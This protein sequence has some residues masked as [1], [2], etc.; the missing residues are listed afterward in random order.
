MTL[1]IEE[2]L[3]LQAVDSEI[4]KLHQEH[5]VLDRGERVD[6]AL[7]VR[8]GRLETAE[9]RLQG[10]EIEQRNSEL[11]LKALEEKKHQEARKLYEGKI[12][13]P[14][15][16]QALEAEIGMLERQRQ[17]LDEGI[18]RRL[19]EIETAKKAVDT[20]RAAVEEAEKALRIIQ[21]RFE[22][23]STRIES[24]LAT[25]APKRERLAAALKPEV[26]RRYDDIRRRNHNLAAVRIENGACAG[27]RM[28]VGGA[29]MR[30][31]LAHDDYVY[32]ESC[33]RFLFPPE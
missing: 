17:R 16:L 7:A 2:I 23:E 3:S 8:Q 27:C 6:R 14:R 15:E 29:L 24:E 4:W 20:T 13:A 18:L 31:V 12:T 30:R 28:K 9:R 32:C 5:E 25:R 22:R 11:E 33:T 10:L 26:L 1:Q 19:D 21:K